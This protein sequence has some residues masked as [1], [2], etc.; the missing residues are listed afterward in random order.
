MPD[1]DKVIRIASRGASLLVGGLMVAVL[2]PQFLRLPIPNHAEALGESIGWMFMSALAAW[3]I[4]YGLGFK[5]GR[6]KR[7]G[8]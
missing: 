7:G 3:A 5:I 6:G 8:A 4:F 2:I 1:M